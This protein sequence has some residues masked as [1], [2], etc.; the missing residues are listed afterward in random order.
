MS[1]CPKCGTEVPADGNF[2][3]ECG[4]RVSDGHGGSVDAH[5]SGTQG[6]RTGESSE[7]DE[8]WKY[9]VDGT[10]TTDPRPQ[11]HKLLI[12]SVIG[13]SALSLIDSLFRILSP[14]TLVSDIITTA[15]D[16]GVEIEPGF[17]ELV[18]MISGVLGI[19]IALT[20]IGLTARS[21]MNESLPKRYFWILI[22]MGIASFLFASNLFLTIL[23]GFGIYGLV[24]VTD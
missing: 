23:I 18:V 19:I 7:S 17:A 14:E 22:G 6:S 16:T 21:Y 9:P 13:L 8:E 2:C 4:T 24:A 11:D 1:E 20:V 15:E 5:P 12:A 3:P 10:V